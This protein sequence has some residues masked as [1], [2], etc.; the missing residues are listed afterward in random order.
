MAD[1]THFS[2]KEDIEMLEV[3]SEKLDATIIVPDEASDNEMNFADTDST[4]LVGWT[5]GG[6]NNSGGGANW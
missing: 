2:R 5:H 1:D 3:Y 6:W 4:S